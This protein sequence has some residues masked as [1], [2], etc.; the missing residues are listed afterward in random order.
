MRLCRALSRQVWPI[1]YGVMLKQQANA[2]FAVNIQRQNLSNSATKKAVVLFGR[3]EKRTLL[4]VELS[5]Q[6]QT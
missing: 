5:I 2:A 3:N 4:V 6:F 1:K